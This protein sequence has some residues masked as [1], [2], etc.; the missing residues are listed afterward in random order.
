MAF[1]FVKDRKPQGLSFGPGGARCLAD[2]TKFR[3]IWGKV[4]GTGDARFTAHEIINGDITSQDG[5]ASLGGSEVLVN[6]KPNYAFAGGNK[7]QEFQ[8][9]IE[10]NEAWNRYEAKLSNDQTRQF[11]RDER[12]KAAVFGRDPDIK[13]DHLDV[14]VAP[15]K[16]DPAPAEKAPLVSGWTPERR[17]AQA[18]KMR[19][20]QAAKKQSP[21]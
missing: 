18:E 16:F 1:T 13:I 5:R 2:Q 15:P 4:D 11:M 8:I 21:E 14:D 12:A 20:R 7:Y 3:S 6:G 19:A 9:P 10:D 17:A